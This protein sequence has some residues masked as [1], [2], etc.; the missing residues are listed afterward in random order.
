MIRI[1][2]VFT[3]LSVYLRKG[4]SIQTHLSKSWCWDLTHTFE[5][6]ILSN[7]PIVLTPRRIV[8][9]R[10]KMTTLKI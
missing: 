6:T 7:E 1:G 9:N 10:F 5:T 4:R 2:D 8:V 3:I